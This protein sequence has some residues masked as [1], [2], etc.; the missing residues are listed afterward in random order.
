MANRTSDFVFIVVDDDKM[1]GLYSTLKEKNERFIQSE[2]DDKIIV[3]IV[4]KKVYIATRNSDWKDRLLTHRE[5]VVLI[6]HSTEKIKERLPSNVYPFQMS[7]I[8]GEPEKIKGVVYKIITP[9]NI[10]ENVDIYK[11]L[12]ENISPF[13]SRYQW[14]ILFHELL[15]P[16]LPLHL[17][18]Q[19]FWG[20]S[21][22]QDSES[23]NVEFVKFG[24]KPV[25]DDKVL[26]KIYDERNERI[27]KKNSEAIDPQ[28]LDIFPNS[29]TFLLVDDAQWDFY[30]P[31]FDKTLHKCGGELDKRSFNCEDEQKEYEGDSF[32]DLIDNILKTEKDE[33]KSKIL[34][35]LQKVFNKPV[36]DNF[37]PCDKCLEGEATEDSVFFQLRT[38][39]FAGP[40]NITYDCFITCLREIAAILANTFDKGNPECH[41]KDAT[42][43]YKGE[44]GVEKNKILGK[45]WSKGE[46]ELK[47]TW[48]CKLP[49]KGGKPTDKYSVLKKQI[50][51]WGIKKAMVV[52]AGIEKLAKCLDECIKESGELWK[53]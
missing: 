38:S 26:K 8:G 47:R 33:E 39:P 24:G 19:I 51:A 41:R 12:K 22:V 23:N 52:I 31:L 46:S 7:G 4:P 45:I 1:R 34:V 6:Y 36:D 37:T 15:N 49:D 43:T 28:L 53:E 30:A 14:W 16:L 35:D 5:A 25:N 44:C 3:E 29:D 2:R 20:I 42:F 18:L 17:S 32:A 40:L 50:A 21:S 27:T 48:H 11:Q 13:I 9:E 10:K